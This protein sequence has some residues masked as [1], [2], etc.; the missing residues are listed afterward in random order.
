MALLN[1][2]STAE[3]AYIPV[4]IGG[5][6]VGYAKDLHWFTAETDFDK[7]ESYNINLSTFK[8]LCHKIRL[9]ASR[10]GGKEFGEIIMLNALGVWEE[11]CD[12]HTLSRGQLLNEEISEFVKIYKRRLS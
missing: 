7:I 11:W 2:L 12:Y 1:L 3:V 10:V 4:E 8:G 9:D 6:I 5:I